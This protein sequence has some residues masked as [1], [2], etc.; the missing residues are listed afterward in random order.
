MMDHNCFR[1]PR[2][3][4]GV[5]DA[6]GMPRPHGLHSLRHSFIRPL[7]VA[8]FQALLEGHDFTYAAILPLDDRGLESAPANDGVEASQLLDV[9]HRGSKLG[10]AVHNCDC[11]IGMVHFVLHLLWGVSGIDSDKLT[12]THHR[13]HSAQG[14]F[15][16]I[17]TEDGDAA[18]LF[19]PQLYKCLCQPPRVV[20][21]FLPCPLGPFLPWQ[22]WSF[23]RSQN[24]RHGLFGGQCHLLAHALSCLF[25]H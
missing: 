18:E 25:E 19:H 22:R 8:K 2:G 23:A 12:A 14:P 16:C 20:I 4:R 9:S 5:D 1:L 6:H 15:R 17:E 11:S 21:V 7:R 13:A 24:M 3:A 10:V